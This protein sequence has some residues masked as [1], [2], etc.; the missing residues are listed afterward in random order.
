MEMKDVVLVAYGRSPGTRARKGGL[1][2][3][4][5]IEYG[6][7][8]L[9]GVL[10]RVPQLKAEDIEDVIMGCA[11]QFR[12]TAMNVSQL[13][14][15]RAGLP[16]CVSGMT[17]NRFC[18]GGLQAISTACNA[19]ACGQGDVYVA[20]GVEAMT[21]TFKVW[22][23]L[24]G[25][26]EDQWL[27]ANYPG[28][29]MSMGQ[30]AENVAQDYNISRVEM[31]EMALQSH[32]KAAA[33]R[34]AGKLAPS[35]IPI[36]KTDLNGNP[37]LDE[38]GNEIWIT[39]DDG[40]LAD[41]DGNL[42]TSMEKMAG[43]KPAFSEDGLVTAA[44]SS[45]TTDCCA[46]VV[47]M[48]AEKAAELGVKPI[49]KLQS[50]AVAGCDATRMGLGPIFATPKALKRAGLTVADLNVIEINEAFASQAKVCKETLGFPEEIT[51]PYGGAMALGHPLGCT[52]AILV[53]KAIDYLRDTYGEDV[54]GKHALIT[55]C[56]GGGMG[57]A[58]V[59][60]ML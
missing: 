30:T 26:A 17:L 2:D 22:P 54:A 35:I 9:N 59:L 1:A 48:S 39:E 21:Q 25:E 4:H 3:M 42:K 50:F 57:A 28:A 6:A 36:K 51:N 43:M 41:A 49:C 8:V 44:T 18:S 60:E 40:I 46:L 58:G 45:Q 12:E 16:D 15:N 31:E 11:M 29:Y 37:V 56:I 24:N 47:L 13:I 52:G 33:A 27:N 55:M 7:Q 20:G 32:I 23:S 19:I 53:G 38:N 10:A 5:P 14:V 34:K